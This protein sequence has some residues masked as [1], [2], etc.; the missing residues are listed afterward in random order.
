MSEAKKPESLVDPAEEDDIL[1]EQ[2]RFLLVHRHDHK[3]AVEDCTSCAR[4]QR[5]IE[6]LL[7]PFV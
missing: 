1:L 5:F 4:A 2:V 3:P 7:N 6:F